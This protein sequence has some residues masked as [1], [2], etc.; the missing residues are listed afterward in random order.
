MRPV[1]AAAIAPS[2]STPAIGRRG[3]DRR[4]QRLELLDDRQGRGAALLDHGEQH[5][6]AAVLAHDVGLDRESVAHVRDVAHVDGGAVDDLDR[7]LVERRHRV[8]AAVEAHPILL[9]PEL[10]AAGRQGQVLEV[11][12]VADIRGRDRLGQEQLRIEV[13]HDLAR[14]AAV[15]Q[16]QRD[17]LD[18]GDLLANAIDAVVVELRLR[19]RLAAERE[20]DDRHARRVVLKD[21]R[22]HRARRHS[23]QN[24]LRHRRDLRQRGFDVH[25]RLEVD[26]DDA[27]ARIG[28]RFD[29]SHVAD[30]RRDRVL[31]ER[32]DP[33]GHVLR[34]QPVKVPDDR[35]DRDVDLLEDVGR[36]RHDRRDAEQQDRES[37]DDEGV[38]APEREPNDPHEPLPPF[39]CLDASAS[40]RDSSPRP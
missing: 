39:P 4:Q 5:R 25:V 28:V 9:R 23:S 40:P 38:G 8:R 18:R 21:E 24:C 29:R 26:L 1:R 14:L 11:D 19:N 31:G 16:R 37:H 34:R 3:A 35:D 22:R 6:S 15:W 36:G 32:R 2:V 12:G 27:D 17:A 30:R 7:E 33:R 20:L 10:H 13:D